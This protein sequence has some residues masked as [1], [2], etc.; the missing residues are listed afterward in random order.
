M[1]IDETILHPEEKTS[2]Q[3]EIAAE[4]DMQVHLKHIE[5]VCPN[6]VQEDTNRTPRMGDGRSLQLMKMYTG[7]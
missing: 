5:Y 7:P 1:G 6:Y 3:G 2:F 4:A